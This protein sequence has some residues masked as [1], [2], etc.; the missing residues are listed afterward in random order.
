MHVLSPGYLLVIVLVQGIG[1][2]AQ[3]ILCRYL[4]GLLCLAIVVLQINSDM[5]LANNSASRGSALIAT[6]VLAVWS[7]ASVVGQEVVPGTHTTLRQVPRWEPAAGELQE[8]M[9]SD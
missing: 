8:G 3:L 1:C 7:V 6:L 9:A 2:F 4:F 5:A